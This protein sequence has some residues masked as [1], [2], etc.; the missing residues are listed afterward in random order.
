MARGDWIGAALEALR[1][2]GACVLVTQCAVDGSAPREAGA[3]MLVR[4]DSF[5]G[6]IGGGNLEHLVLQQ[7]RA[8]FDRPDLTVLLQDYPLGPL[9]SQCCGGHVR[10]LLERFSVE[11]VDW[12]NNLERKILQTGGVVLETRLDKS[13]PLK[14]V[15]E[16]EGVPLSPDAPF[17]DTA[18]SMLP[19]A[20]P[21]RDQC[22]FYREFVCPPLPPVFIFGAGHVGRALVRVLSASDFQLYWYDARPEYEGVMG[23]VPVQLLN[24]PDETA[25]SLPPRAIC[26]VFTHAHELDYQITRAVLRRGDFLYCGLIGSQTKRMRFIRRLAADGLSQASIARL[27]CPIGLPAIEGKTPF[28]IALSVA[29]ELNALVD[30]PVSEAAAAFE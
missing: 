9:L 18:G 16:P 29:A 26:L 21:P 2:Q 1:Q 23:A 8:L 10:I 19:G 24:G 5:W 7:A 27:T 25:A 28:A 11:D 13:G 14:R 20:R 15:L 6:T 22:T 17:L 12:L 3:R 4:P 30:Q